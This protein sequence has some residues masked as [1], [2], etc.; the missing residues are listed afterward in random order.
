LTLVSEASCKPETGLLETLLAASFECLLFFSINLLP[1]QGLEMLLS[2]TLL[3][4]VFS[5]PTLSGEAT[6][7]SGKLEVS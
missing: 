5:L 3:L 4:E 2:A 7:T 1:S 6:T